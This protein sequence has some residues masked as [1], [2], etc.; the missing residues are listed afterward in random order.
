MPSIARISAQTTTQYADMIA[1]NHGAFFGWYGTAR[2]VSI[3]VCFLLTQWSTANVSTAGASSSSATTA[4]LWKSCWPITSLNT[5]VAS[6]L[7]LPPMTLGMPKSVMTSV[8]VTS[9]AEIRPYLAP[10]KVM[11]KN[12][13]AAVVPIESAASYRRASA[14]DSAVTRII[15]AC[16]KVENA[17]ATTMPGA[18]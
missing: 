3:A 17:S 13:R 2:A 1:S 4:P 7:K 16:G 14:A 18:P 5:S 9:A 11:V 10:G 15:S 6:T 8:K 12:L